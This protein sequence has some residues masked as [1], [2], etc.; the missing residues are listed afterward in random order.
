MQRQWWSASEAL[1]K[2]GIDLLAGKEISWDTRIRDSLVIPHNTVFD[3]LKTVL[4]SRLFKKTIIWVVI[5]LIIGVLVVVLQ[6]NS[7]MSDYKKGGLHNSIEDHCK[8][9]TYYGISP[10]RCN[11][12]I[13]YLCRRSW[14]SIDHV[15][16]T[17]CNKHWWCTATCNP[18][19]AYCEW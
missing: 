3:K 7:M 18:S 8:E 10:S 13:K 9:H 4:S 12:T 16:W 14:W 19:Y 15:C 6:I 1:K 5:M 2:Q 11:K 17:T